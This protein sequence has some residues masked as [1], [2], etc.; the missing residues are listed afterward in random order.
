M[1]END[2]IEMEVGLENEK[3]KRKAVRV[4]KGIEGLEWSERKI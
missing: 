2:G 1:E 3:R 4:G